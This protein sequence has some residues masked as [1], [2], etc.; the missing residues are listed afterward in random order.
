MCQV[1]ENSIKKN[2]DIQQKRISIFKTKYVHIFKLE[3]QMF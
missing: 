2:K 1:I 3:K